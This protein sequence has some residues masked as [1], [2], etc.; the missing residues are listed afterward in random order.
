[1]VGLDASQR[2]TSK[3]EMIDAHESC[4]AKYRQIFVA[5]RQFKEFNAPGLIVLDNPLLAGGY[6]YKDNFYLNV[7]DWSNGNFKYDVENLTLHETIPGHHLQLDV[8]YHSPKH[9]YLTAI[10]GAP[11]NG[12][13]EGWGLFSEH[14]G[15]SMFDRPW[16]Y[17]GYLQANIL[18]TYRIIAE[19]LLHVEGESPTAVIELAQRYLTTSKECITSEIYRYRVLPGQA[20]AYKTG[21]E[22]FKRII[23]KKFNVVQM[24]DFT[25]SDLLDWYKEV[26]WNTERPLDV[27]LRENGI[28]WT[29]DE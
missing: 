2:W 22:V 8:S 24:K 23:K 21:L 11:C 1:M 28:A 26:I 16:V 17:F 14:L 9:N 15:D 13:V 4:I 7:C 18:R 29:F 25:R 6:Y 19:I 20:C 27:F 5:Q 3:Q 12:F 10:D